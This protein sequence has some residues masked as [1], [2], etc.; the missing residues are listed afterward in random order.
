MYFSSGEFKSFLVAV[1]NQTQVAVIYV[2]MCKASNTF[3]SYLR[4]G[5]LIIT[6]ICQNYTKYRVISVHNIAASA[7]KNVTE[8][9]FRAFKEYYKCYIELFLFVLKVCVSF[10]TILFR[11]IAQLLYLNKPRASLWRTTTNLFCVIFFS[12]N[13]RLCL[14]VYVAGLL[15]W[16]PTHLYNYSNSY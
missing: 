7:V 3:W 10:L 12:L 6:F 5:V 2:I 1:Q 16:P 13:L 14:S 15:V 9:P 11:H 8:R 4:C